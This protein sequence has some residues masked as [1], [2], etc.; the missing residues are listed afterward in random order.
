[1][2]RLALMAAAGAVLLTP[3]TADAGLSKT[4]A[5]AEAA[6][7]ITP[8]EAESVSCFRVVPRTR[9]QAKVD[10][11]VCVVFSAA[12]PGDQCLTTVS[13]SKHK[14]S[15]RVRTRIIVP[16]RCFPQWPAIGSPEAL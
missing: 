6:R 3:A 5:Q 7:A 10:R 11:Q 2:R 12:P 15:R 8:L 14:R 1:M 4:R 13:V 16:H 9:R